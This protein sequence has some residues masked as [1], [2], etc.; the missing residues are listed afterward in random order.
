MK[1]MTRLLAGCFLSLCLLFSGVTALAAPDD[2]GE[3]IDPSLPAASGRTNTPEEETGNPSGTEVGDAGGFTLGEDGR[4]Q[5]STAFFLTI[6]KA[7]SGGGGSGG[8]SGGSGGIL[9][10]LCFDEA[11]FGVE[12]VIQARQLPCVVVA[13]AGLGTIN[14]VGLTIFYM[15]QKGIAVKGVL[16]N[17]YSPGNVMQEDNIK[18]CEHITGVPVVA[19]V[20]DG[21]TDI[22]LTKEQLE[23]LFA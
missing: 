5:A 12:D 11:E 6:E 3:V 10:P 15:Q 13:D 2:T 7:P 22:A 1:R 20:Q 18:M 19:C 4:L 21:D 16:M 17:H 23:A 14:H 8:S 9:C